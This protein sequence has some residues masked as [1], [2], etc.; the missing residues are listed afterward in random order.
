MKKERYH[1]PRSLM[2]G[3]VSLLYPPVCPLCDKTLPPGESGRLCGRCCG[4]LKPIASP[5]CL[6]CGRQ[7]EHSE[8]ECCPQCRNR[9]YSFKRGFSVFGYEGEAR[10]LIL[11]LKYNGRKDIAEY[12]ANI[13]IEKYGT[14]LEAIGA[15]AVV[16]VPIHKKRLK[17][18]GYNQ[19]QAIAE[20]L[21]EKLNIPCAEELLVRTKQTEAQKKLTVQERFLNLNDAF[22]VDKNA[23]KEYQKRMTLKKVILVDDIYTT[24]STMECCSRTLLES[25]VKEIWFICMTSVPA[26]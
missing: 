23:L 13:T 17:Q 8:E 7:L 3:I 14:S 5:A 26:I 20:I 22:S 15:D 21:G 25:G 1:A 6:K 9:N 12:F 19:A 24:G 10:E 2:R 11:K 4:K 16:P 18:R